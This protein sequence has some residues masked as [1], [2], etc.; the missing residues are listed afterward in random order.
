[1]RLSEVPGIIGLKDATSDLV[2]HVELMRRLPTNATFKLYSGNDDTALAYML[3]GGHGVI[4][5]TAK[6]CT[7]RHAG[8]VSCRA[9]REDRRSAGSE[10]AAHAF[11]YEAFC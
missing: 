8:A 7:A 2:R 4:S 5:V 6:R 9:Y 10:Y 11:T 1:M 3:L